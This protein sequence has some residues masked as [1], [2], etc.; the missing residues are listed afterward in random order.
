MTRTLLMLTLGALVACKGGVGHEDADFDGDG[1]LPPSYGGED[2]DNHDASVHPGA[3]EVCDGIDNDCDETVDEPDATDAIEWYTDHDGDSY[4]DQSVSP[5]RSCEAPEDHVDRGGDC[6][7]LDP[8]VNPGASDDNCNGI[9]DDCDGDVDAFEDA[10]WWYDGDGD[11]YG[12]PL[13]TVDAC[14]QPDDYVLEPTDATD[15]DCDDARP[16]VYPGADE[17]CDG[18]DN[19]C[20]GGMV[21]AD[22]DDLVPSESHPILEWYADA[23]GD[24]YGDPSAGVVA[25]T[26]PAGHV[27]DDTDCDDTDPDTHPGAVEHCDGVDEDCDGSVDEDAVDPTTWYA[28]GDGDGWGLD[29]STYVGCVAPMDYVDRGGDCDGANASSY[30]GAPELCDDLDND[31][32]GLAEPEDPD[33]GLATTTYYLDGDGDGYGDPA[34]PYDDCA[35][36]TGYVTNDEDCD[37]SRVGVNPGAT[38]VVWYD[39]TDQDCDGNDCDADGDGQDVMGHAST[40]PGGTD[41]DDGHDA[42]YVGAAPLDSTTECMA[43]RDGDGY[44]DDSP[45]SAGAHPGTDCDDLDG[46][47]HPGATESWYNGVDED[48]DGNDC[49]ADGDGEAVAGESWCSGGTDCD[50]GN[51]IVHTGASDPP[52]DG[53]D[54]DC[55]GWSDYD[56][57]RDGHD[58]DAYGGDDCDDA[59]ATAYPGGAAGREVWYN[60]VDEDCDGNDCDADGDGQDAEGELA[61]WGGTD[62]DDADASTWTGAAWSDDPLECMT[63]ADGDG[64]GDEA[65]ASWV[66]AGTDCDDGDTAVAPELWEIP[67]DH[68]D[69]DCDGDVDTVDLSTYYH[70]A[71][72][73]TSPHSSGGT[74]GVRPAEL[75]WSLA[76][77]GYDGASD[78]YADYLVG[79]PLYSSSVP[80]PLSD[81]G[82]VGLYLGGSSLPASTSGVFGADVTWVGQTAGEQLGL[83]VAAVYSGGVRTHLAMMA[84]DGFYLVDLATVPVTDLAQAQWVDSMYASTVGE[85]PTGLADIGN[86][87]ASTAWTELAVSWSHRLGEGVSIWNQPTTSALAQVVQDDQTSGSA[88]G[89]AVAAGDVSRTHSGQELFMTTEDVST[90]MYM[91]PS[92]TSGSLVHTSSLWRLTTT[93]ATECGGDP[94]GDA[95]RTLAVLDFDGD[96]QDEIALGCPATDGGEGVVWLLKPD[97]RGVSQTL[98][99][100]SVARMSITSDGGGPYTWETG[101][102]IANAGDVDGDGDEDLLLSAPARSEAH[103]RGRVFLVLGI[104]PPATIPPALPLDAEAL[105]FDD[106]AGIE[107]GRALAGVGDVDGQHGVDFVMSGIND[108]GSG[109]ENETVTLITWGP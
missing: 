52:Y 15:A 56:A 32:D 3:E 97:F 13:Q 2:C 44:G 103:T 30:P 99:M 12:D 63:D 71:S 25:C 42:I 40:C 101:F 106:P 6:D 34:S 74:L 31:C 100:A 45:T 93:G 102:A 66:T 24:L 94:T 1:Y 65:A 27:A 88:F 104:Q 17:V 98:R 54:Q 95:H 81:R 7:D 72:V 33:H 73:H 20:D 61:C 4:G 10:T 37:D 39:G 29:T 76:A 21:D 108:N 55:D 49:D 82:A 87:D 51:A 77:A 11:G 89:L 48:C 19:D 84:A 92:G 79:S 38:E 62:C 90:V 57:D 80:S 5:V 109:G 59:D 85:V 75:G 43:D 47:I 14:G 64:W 8:E 69:N 70:V 86:Y 78:A 50:D 105:P 41:C 107:P 96:G 36:P 67:N 68:E 60:S 83:D 9:D 23:D 35:L 16:D 46:A 58:H 28:D 91:M 18:V 53:V 22:D 26:A